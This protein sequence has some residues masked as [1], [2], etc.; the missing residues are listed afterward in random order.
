MANRI[1]SGIATTITVLLY[2][3]AIGLLVYGF[4]IIYRVVR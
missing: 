2:G 3:L 4:L 1:V